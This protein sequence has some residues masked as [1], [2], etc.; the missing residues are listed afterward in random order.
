MK[1][2]TEKAKPITAV[3][4]LALFVTM[5]LVPSVYAQQTTASQPQQ[6]GIPLGPPYG[7]NW[8]TV[9]GEIYALAAGIGVVAIGCGIAISLV[10]RNHK[11]TVSSMR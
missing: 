10:H 6:G 1:A 7:P 4:V 3:G 2:L 8:S 11:K 9:Q 5:A